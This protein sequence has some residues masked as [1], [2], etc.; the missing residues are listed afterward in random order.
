MKEVTKNWINDARGLNAVFLFTLSLLSVDSAH[1]QELQNE[2][3][4]TSGTMVFVDLNA[5]NIIDDGEPLGVYQ[6]ENKFNITLTKSQAN[7][8]LYKK[9]GTKLIAY[10]ATKL[11]TDQSYAKY[12]SLVAKHQSAPLFKE[13]ILQSVEGKLNE[14]VTQRVTN[15]LN[16]IEEEMNKIREEIPEF[17]ALQTEL[18]KNPLKLL[19]DTESSLSL[20]DA[21]LEMKAIMI[22]SIYSHQ[23]I[24]IKSYNLINRKLNSLILIADNKSIPALTE[25]LDSAIENGDII[26][27]SFKATFREGTL[28]LKEET[29]NFWKKST[30]RLNMTES[31]IYIKDIEVTLVNMGTTSRASAIRLLRQAAFVSDESHIAS[32]IKDGEIAWI[33]K[34]LNMEGDLDR[35]DDKKYGYLESMT[36]FLHENN[37]TKYPTS[38][39]NNPFDAYPEDKDALR[40]RVFNRSIWWQKALHNEDQLRQRVA[41]AL[42]QLI[43]VG[44]DGSGHLGF[45][46]EAAAHYYDIL[47]DHAFG[48]Y[49]DLL[50]K[51]SMNA[52]MASYLTYV[53]S[54]KDNNVTGTAPDENYARELM[55]LFSVG[56]YELNDD[57]TKVLTNNLPT[58]VYTQEDV[59]QMAKVFTGWALNSSN[60]GNGDK[61]DTRMQKRNQKYTDTASYAH[62][63]ILPIRSHNGGEFHDSTE[64]TVLKETIQAGLSPEADIDRA[65]EILMTN[66]NIG[67]HVCRELINRLVT[68]NP[69]KKYMKDVVAVFNGT[70]NESGKKGDLKATIK[71]ILTH[72]EARD[73]QSSVAHGKVDEFTLLTT[74]YL[75]SLNIKPLPL[76]Y[77]TNIENEK[78]TEMKN[79]YWFTPDTQFYHQVV[80]EAPSVFNFYSPEYIPNDATFSDTGLVAPEFELRTYNGL[81]SF[82]NYIQFNLGRDRYIYEHMHPFIGKDRTPFTNMT[83]WAR[84]HPVYQS[85]FNGL[86]IDTTEIYK[87]FSVLVDGND[88]LEFK[89]LNAGT[90]VQGGIKD[91]SEKGKEAVVKLIEYLD[92]HFTGGITPQEYR[93]KLAQHLYT[94]QRSRNNIKLQANNIVGTAIKA[95]VMS[96]S[97]MVIK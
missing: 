1:S 54:S 63:Y 8:P 38:L 10:G 91:L 90:D 23:S 6:K 36:R 85:S 35:T 14:R 97:Y 56:L 74:H 76:T 43:V 4:I 34:Q 2:K 27:K 49:G 69:S 87:E 68:S 51:V 59:S 64:K 50:K 32:I 24:F 67:P 46:G 82:S 37:P 5:N 73:E 19:E 9:N 30:Q 33:N 11:K 18:T 55:Q 71:A 53:A 58:P 89:N 62:S 72:A 45:R 77:Y 26:D 13:K 21:T 75:S 42:S 88:K 39:Y 84:N 29:I 60:M 12:L 96:P 17:L 65:I 92:N 86:Y 7:E 41:Y 78:K 70:D 80:L 20:H 93:T 40:L 48:N 94:T 16:Q 61:D 95:I 52:T 47:V 66:K 15:L 3:S 44:T 57:G 25:A 28:S 83:D 31:S 81:I 22:K 79:V